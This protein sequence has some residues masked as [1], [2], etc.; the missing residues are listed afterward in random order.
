MPCIPRAVRRLALF[1][2]A[3]APNGCVSSPKAEAARQQ[4]L[5]E[6]GDALNEL[7]IATTTLTATVDSLR[8]VIAKQDTT[9]A[10]LANVTGV[11]LVK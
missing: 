9:L 5:L 4:Q 8:N 2:L 10:R 7:R 11:V 6:L 1:I 3:A